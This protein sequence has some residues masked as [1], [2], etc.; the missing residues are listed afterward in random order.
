MGLGV[1]PNA[2]LKEFMDPVVSSAIEYII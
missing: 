2:R 1:M